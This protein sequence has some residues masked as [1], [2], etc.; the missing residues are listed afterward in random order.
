MTVNSQRSVHASILC[1]AV[2]IATTD[3][4]SAAGNDARS[5]LSASGIKGGLVVHVGCGNG[6]LTAALRATDKFLVHGLEP[7][8]A[9]VAAARAHV[10]SVGLAGKVSIAQWSVG[11]LPYADN[12]VNLLVL[13]GTPAVAPREALRVLCP[14]G[15]IMEKQGEEW[16][17]TSK[18]RPANIDEWTHFLHD[19]G[20][21]AVAQDERV[22]PPRHIQWLAD[23]LWIR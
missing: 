2:C 12:I 22:G 6:Q 4:A 15:A 19:G 23:P 3:T 7:N 5:I 13:E 9:S 20:G 11:R 14:G 17:M 10:E 21:N 16:A 18:P 8:A 1:C